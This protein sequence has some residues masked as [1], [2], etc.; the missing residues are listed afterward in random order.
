MIETNFGKA[1]FL[2]EGFKKSWE[3]ITKYPKESLFPIVLMFVNNLLL[4]VISSGIESLSVNTQKGGVSMNLETFSSLHATQFIY[5]ILV[6]LGIVFLY[7]FIEFYC[8][9]IGY[10]WFS[11]S[12]EPSLS[13]DL[14]IDY[15]LFGR[16]LLL[17]LVYGLIVL[18]GTLLFI[19]P[20]I[21]WSMMYF[22]STR[23]F[24]MHRSSIKESLT[25]SSKL[26]YGVK[27]Q[28]FGTTLLVGIISSLFSDSDNI[29]VN[30][31]LGIITSFISVFMSYAYTYLFIDL[32]QQTFS[33]TED[34]S[35]DPWGSTAPE[36]PDFLPRNEAEP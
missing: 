23:Y 16:F 18:G 17:S 8:I 6:F 5:I 35:S 22:F 14:R 19:I 7:S 21:V 4:L 34:E 32:H 33:D 29:I 30:L 24:I 13:V 11:S 12:E 3:F 27:W 15:R 28:L 20:G 31:I 25:G 1:F 2:L 9:R 10:K 26:A 36:N